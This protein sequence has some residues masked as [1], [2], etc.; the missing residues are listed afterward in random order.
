MSRDLDRHIHDTGETFLLLVYFLEK[1]EQEFIDMSD[2]H[3]GDYWK[4]IDRINNTYNKKEKAL[5]PFL[6][7][8]FLGGGPAFELRTAVFR[9]LEKCH[10]D[11][12][13]HN[14]LQVVG[15]KLNLSDYGRR[16][17][18]AEIL[19][20]LSEEDIKK[21]TKR[22]AVFAKAIREIREEEAK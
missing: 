18:E 13:D 19:P 2:E 4:P 22:A 14:R 1:L 9:A 17:V 20:M 10:F 12:M 5:C 15:G 3:A 8:R 7:L 21:Q 6:R 16:K 11:G